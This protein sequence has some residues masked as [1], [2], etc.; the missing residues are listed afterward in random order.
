MQAVSNF[1]TKSVPENMH[2]SQATDLYAV[3]GVPFPLLKK[4]IKNPYLWV[5][6]TTV[7]ARITVHS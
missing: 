2:E 6:N 7:V 5:T 3:L 1:C 4:Y